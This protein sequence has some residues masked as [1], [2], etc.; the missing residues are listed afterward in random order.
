[1]KV[2]MNVELTLKEVNRIRKYAEKKRLSEIDAVDKLVRKGKLETLVSI[3]ALV[4]GSVVADIFL[5]LNK[6]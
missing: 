3:K 6:K 2:K 1:M 5:K 4:E